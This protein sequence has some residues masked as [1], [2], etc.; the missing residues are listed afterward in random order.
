MKGVDPRL[1]F[2]FLEGFANATVTVFWVSLAVIVVAFILSF[3]MKAQPLRMKSALQE[4]TE[5][6]HAED[7]A[8]AEL[9]L[10]HSAADAAGAMIEPALGSEHHSDKP[11]AAKSASPEA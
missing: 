7:A 3:F 10:A 2:P 5:S 4:Q 1:S 11:A 6:D 9:I 8:E